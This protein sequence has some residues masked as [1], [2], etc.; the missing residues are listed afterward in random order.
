[1]HHFGRSGQAFCGA[2]YL[3]AGTITQDVQAVD[4]TKCLWRLFAEA[5]KTC[6]IIAFRIK[7]VTDE[8][9]NELPESGAV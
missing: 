8:R 2:S 5:H 3:L 6:D 7:L 1:M 4:C 9:A